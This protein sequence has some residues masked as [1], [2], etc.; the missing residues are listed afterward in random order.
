M[1]NESHKDDDDQI[2]NRLDEIGD[3]CNDYDDKEESDD[4]NKEFEFDDGNHHDNEDDG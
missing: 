4:T 1:L 3:H 2:Q